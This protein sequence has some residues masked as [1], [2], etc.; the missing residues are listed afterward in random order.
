MYFDFAKKNIKRSLLNLPFLGFNTNR[1]LIVIESDDWGSQRM[2][3][4]DVLSKCLSAGYAIDRSNIFERYDSLEGEEDLMKLYDVL[5]KY[6]D[7]KGNHPIFTMD[8]IMS[9][10]NY[11]MIKESNFKEYYFEKFT[12]TYK[13][14]AHTAGAFEIIN[15]GIVAKLIKPQYHGREHINVPKWLNAV[16]SKNCNVVFPFEN[17]FASLPDKNNIENKNDFTITLDYTDIQER[18]VINNNLIDG[19]NIFEEIFGFRSRSFV[20][21][22]CVW[23]SNHEKKLSE[24]GVK[25]LQ[26]VC[27]QTLPNY[28]GCKNV[29]HFIIGQKNEYGQRYLL[30]NCLFEPIFSNNIAKHVG[31]CLND[32]GMAF[33]MGKPAT[34]STHR[35]N[36]IGSLDEKKREVNLFYLDILL[37]S[38]LYKWPEVEFITS[39]ELGEI[40]DL[41]NV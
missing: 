9:N 10:P 8:F 37:K 32:I 34:I 27:T 3:S 23:D 22:S 20:A 6:K 15:E 35:I 24:N 4:K 14:N 17:D 12:E 36:Y 39:D 16:K 41:K 28:Y 33:F 29:K 21:P 40:I 7:R 31:S 2:P 18:D 30:R 26:T 5:L 25:Y 13:K 1:K 19:L 38:I 11:D